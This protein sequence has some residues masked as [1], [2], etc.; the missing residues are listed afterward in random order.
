MSGED[1][2]YKPAPELIPQYFKKGLRDNTYFFL[3]VFL[4][5]LFFNNVKRQNLENSNDTKN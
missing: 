1:S 4:F 2:S 3:L 5:F